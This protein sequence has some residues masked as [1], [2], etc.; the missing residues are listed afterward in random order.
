MS[1]A[2]HRLPLDAARPARPLRPLPALQSI[3][4]AEASAVLAT[5]LSVGDSDEC[6]STGF[7]HAVRL[8]ED[9]HWE[10]AFDHLTA[11]ADDGHAPAAK[12]SL[13]MLRYGRSL[14]GTNFSAC[15]E[16][17]ARWAQRVLRATSRATSRATA[18]PSSITA[19][20]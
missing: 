13:L 20:A 3:G 10:F 19:S 15:P 12:L 16:Q 18:S 11:L 6:A 9:C 7:A 8:Y 5:S 14:Y 4:L 17:I 2:I 1:H